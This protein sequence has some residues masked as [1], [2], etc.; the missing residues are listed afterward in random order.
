MTALAKNFDK[1]SAVYRHIAKNI[2]DP[3]VARSFEQIQRHQKIGDGTTSILDLGCG[4]GSTLEKIQ[5]LF[6]EAQFTGVDISEKMLE[7]ARHKLTLKTILSDI[8]RVQDTLPKAAFDLIL[9]H[10]VLGYIELPVLLDSARQA[11]KPQG[12]LSI[13][14]STEDSFTSVKNVVRDSCSRVK[15]LKKF[16]DYKIRQGIKNSKNRIDWERLED[17]VAEKG[18]QVVEFET[19]NVACLFNDAAELFN[20]IFCGSWGIG[21]LK[22]YIPLSLYRFF[23]TRLLSRLIQF[24][25]EDKAQVHITLLQRVR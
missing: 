16:I 25:L 22:P 2:Y 11:L 9:S 8:S 18:F 7:E 24:P 3:A 12:L 14:T 13:A 15:P 17:V 5:V 10:F 21:E 19:L 6:P 20:Y 1:I 4:D 23:Y